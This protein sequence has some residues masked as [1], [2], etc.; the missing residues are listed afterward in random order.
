M[1]LSTLVFIFENILCEEQESLYTTYYDF[2]P[3][4]ALGAF[5]PGRRAQPQKLWDGDQHRGCPRTT[6]PLPRPPSIDGLRARPAKARAPALF[7]GDTLAHAPNRE[8]LPILSR[9]V[10]QHTQNAPGAEP[11]RTVTHHTPTAVQPPSSSSLQRYGRVAAI[12][13]C[14]DRSLRCPARPYATTSRWCCC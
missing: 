4:R 13:G 6:R 14:F 10:Q 2:A 1:Y 7:C 5:S 3:S 12:G 8:S 9:R 11:E